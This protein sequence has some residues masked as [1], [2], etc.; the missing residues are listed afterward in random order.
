MPTTLNKHHR[1]RRVEQ[2]VGLAFVDID[3][4]KRI[5]D[6][7]GHQAGD[8]VLRAISD[9]MCAVMRPYDSVGRFG[10]EEFLIVLP[11][12]DEAN[13]RKLCERL[14]EILAETSILY[15]NKT[16][17]CT[18][19][20]GATLWNPTKEPVVEVLVRAADL[21]LYRAKSGG[22]NRVELA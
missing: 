11:G 12:C 21:A 2:P 18:V 19:S 17:S 7:Y 20:I 3:H 1:S 6:T 10:G 4:F 5:N 14:R 13:L 22:R 9:K 15:E 8:A 16:I